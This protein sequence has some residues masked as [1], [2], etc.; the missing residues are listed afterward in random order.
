MRGESFFPSS[1]S[2]TDKAACKT[3]SA[4]TQSERRQHL[5][6][7]QS[8]VLNMRPRKK[9]IRLAQGCFPCF[10]IILCKCKI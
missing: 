4:N 7:S 5:E 3:L 6:M 1:P 10:R 2:P 9:I 8:A